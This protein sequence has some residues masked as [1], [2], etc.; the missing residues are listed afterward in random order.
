MGAESMAAVGRAEF[1]VGTARVG[2]LQQDQGRDM[3]RKFQFF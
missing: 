1:V 3:N 2:L